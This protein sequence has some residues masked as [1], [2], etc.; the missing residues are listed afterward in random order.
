M[1]FLLGLI[2]AGMDKRMRSPPFIKVAVEAI[3]SFTVTYF[4]VSAFLS[5]DFVR[6]PVKIPTP[7]SCNR[8]GVG[9]LGTIWV[10]VET[11]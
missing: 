1:S 8:I 3:T 5:A 2:G 7:Y 10:S 11:I 9:M 6:A 4:L